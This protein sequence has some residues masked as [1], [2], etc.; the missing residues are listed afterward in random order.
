MA[1]STDLPI[2]EKALVIQFTGVAF[3]AE[4]DG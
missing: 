2:A 3:A 4:L 1:P